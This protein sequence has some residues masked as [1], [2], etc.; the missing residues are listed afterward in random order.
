V[1]E[2]FEFC[3]PTSGKIFPTGADWLHEVKYDGYR[4]RP[5]RAGKRVRL[6]TKAAKAR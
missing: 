4:P 2:P 1:F 5:E 3:V 6:I